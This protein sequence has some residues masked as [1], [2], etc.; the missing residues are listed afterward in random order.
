MFLS[1]LPTRRE[2]FVIVLQPPFSEANFLVWFPWRSHRVNYVKLGGWEE[3]SIKPKLTSKEN[4]DV[5]ISFYMKI[6]KDF[7]S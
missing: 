7:S 4:N 3:I 6:T 1:L 5:A 2:M